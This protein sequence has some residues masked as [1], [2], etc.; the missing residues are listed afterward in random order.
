MQTSGN[1]QY[2]DLSVSTTKIINWMNTMNQY[3]LGIYID[4]DSTVTTEDNPNVALANFNLITYTSN[5]TLTDTM[6]S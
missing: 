6:C 1:A 3:G 5:S 2:V 4:S